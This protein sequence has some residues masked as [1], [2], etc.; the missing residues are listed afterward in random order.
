MSYI[1][2]APIQKSSMDAAAI[3]DSSTHGSSIAITVL[4]LHEDKHL[5]VLSS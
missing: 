3:C 1:Y 4:M 5:A 2:G